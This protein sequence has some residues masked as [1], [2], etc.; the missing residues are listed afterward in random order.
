MYL[1]IFSF[2]HA[3]NDMVIS[4]VVKAM[5]DEICEFDVISKILLHNKHLQYEKKQL[6][7]FYHL[8]IRR[9]VNTVHMVTKLKYFD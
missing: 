4:G 6:L 8:K 7:M 2:Y 9:C 1:V 5:N 3:V